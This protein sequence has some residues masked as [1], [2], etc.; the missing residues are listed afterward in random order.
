MKCHA[1]GKK[2]PPDCQLCKTCLSA[3][4]AMRD[5]PDKPAT[6]QEAVDLL[7][8]KLR[9]ELAEECAQKEAASA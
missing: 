1:C 2:A 3:V 4:K 5:S 8:A 6:F 9:Y 7:T